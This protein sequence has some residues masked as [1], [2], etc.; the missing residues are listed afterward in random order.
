MSTAHRR[1]R[2]R[3][4]ADEIEQPVVNHPD[5]PEDEAFARVRMT[6]WKYAIVRTVPTIDPSTIMIVPKK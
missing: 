3:H 1:V 2:E 5:R 6:R 4:D